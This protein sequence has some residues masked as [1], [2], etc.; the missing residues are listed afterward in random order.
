VKILAPGLTLLVLAGCAWGPGSSFAS[1]EKATVAA[2][3]P[4]ENGRRDEAGRLKTD[5][6]YRLTVSEGQVR[7]YVGALDLLGPA[8]AAA[9]GTG[10][11]FDPA[12]PPA[13]YTLCHSGHC[14]R[15]D[16][17]L[18]SYEDVQAQLAGGGAAAPQQVLGLTPYTQVLFVPVGGETS[19]DAFLCNGAMSCMMP[20]GSVA[21]SRLDVSRLQAYGQAEAEPG[22]PALGAAPLR[23]ELDLTTEAL[24][25]SAKTP[26]TIDRTS[27]YAL[28]LSGRLAMTDRLFD[29]IEWDRLAQAANGA[30]VHLEAD[31]KTKETLLANL[32]KASWTAE[33]KRYP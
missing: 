33:L 23:W 19:S 1:L 32:A 29:G 20:Q 22:L 3:L 13:G 9:A 24:S 8:T 10:A 17:A 31:A 11:A 14:H 21:T 5:N 18:V 7:V 4:I 2:S 27:P 6:G 28:G 30:T 15:T 16:G 26:A 12:H 25:Y